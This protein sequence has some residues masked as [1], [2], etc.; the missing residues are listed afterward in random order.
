MDVVKTTSA[1]DYHAV[2]YHRFD[3]FTGSCSVICHAIVCAGKRCVN[4]DLRAN[5]RLLRFVS[6]AVRP[7]HISPDLRS[8]VPVCLLSVP[9]LHLSKAWNAGRCS[10]IYSLERSKMHFYDMTCRFV[11]VPWGQAHRMAIEIVL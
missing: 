1:Y 2:S 8:A 7:G 3:L 9:A 4:I 5:L 11:L 10:V 6:Y